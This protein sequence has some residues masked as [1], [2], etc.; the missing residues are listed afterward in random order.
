MFA[1]SRLFPRILTA[2]FI[3]LLYAAAPFGTAAHADAPP[4]AEA[5]APKDL[6]GRETP[7]GL[8]RGLVKA[9]A[10]QDYVRAANYFDLSKIP[11][12]QRPA[13]GK[14]LAQDLQQVLD[15]G[16]WLAQGRELSNAPEGLLDDGLDAD[17]EKFAS[18]RTHQGTV[19]L[20][21]QRVKSPDG[22]QIWLVSS[23]SVA[24]I[25]GLEDKVKAGIFER[26]LPRWLLGGPLLGGVPL[27]HWGALV[28]FAVLAYAVSGLVTVIAATGLRSIWRRNPDSL[29][30]RLV[31]AAVPPFRICF[32]V[33]LFVLGV[34]YLGV[35]VV[36]RQF[37]AV[38]GQIV[39]WSGLAWFLWRIV[40]AVAQ[41]TI[42]KI[43]QLNHW[44]ALS[45]IRFFR[46]VAKF[47]VMA[48]GLIV[49]L[50][51]LGFNVSAGLAALGIG[52]IAVALGAQKTI[53]NLIGSVTLIADHPIREGDF[54]KFGDQLGQVEEIGM[55]S[56]R[57]RTLD[58]TIV[59]VPNGEFSSLKIENF[60]MRDKFWFHP[61][62]G[63]R[64]ETTPDQIRYLLIELR[65]MLLSH[66]KVDPDPARV[67]F[68]GL[69]A[70][71][72]TIEIF[73][74]VK[75]TDMNEFLQI[76]E[77]LTLRIMDIVDACGAGFAFPS[78][79]VYMARDSKPDEAKRLMVEEK[80]RTLRGISAETGEAVEAEEPDQ[81]R[82]SS[83]SE[84]PD[85]PEQPE[86]GVGR[87]LGRIGISWRP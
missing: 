77:E 40:D 8:V 25:P 28:V 26:I 51:T 22:I 35:A 80:I 64:Y 4:A 6:L 72:L 73:A 39:W 10:E 12:T 3:F 49:I 75:C 81:P 50:D 54:C 86:S 53:E 85:I 47:L 83:T 21:L 60:A 44:E 23:R 29:K 56:T 46:R 61:K 65:A 5:P 82:P 55:R 9:M 78:Q 62:L 31:E 33:M 15:E 32:A 1:F 36:A 30:R 14:D 84:T 66:P 43:S 52:G 18:V 24:Q 38:I 16:G 63:L 68:T 74:Y 45:A 20:F 19:D 87:L 48:A 13:R 27:I 59:T 71:S 58:R 67:R 70:D 11:T 17:L 41:V 34:G 2:I 69:G 37:F 42:D 79:T 76:Q 57:I 7:E